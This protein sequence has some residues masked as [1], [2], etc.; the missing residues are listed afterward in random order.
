LLSLGRSRQASQSRKN[1]LPPHQRS[2]RSGGVIPLFPSESDLLGTSL[3]EVELEN[4]IQDVQFKL[5]SAAGEMDNQWF[6]LL[7]QNLASGAYIRLGV[8]PSAEGS[9]S[10]S[11]SA[12]AASSSSSSAPS[13]SPSVAQF[14]TIRTSVSYARSCR[15]HHSELPHQYYC[16][17]RTSVAS[18]HRRSRTYYEHYPS[19]T[20]HALFTGR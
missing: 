4:R 3:D 1:R 6:A 19:S 12:P 9:G 2:D 15:I 13:N 7:N 8:S 14:S 20:A 16:C 5:V 11:N 17:Q 10:G 18:Y